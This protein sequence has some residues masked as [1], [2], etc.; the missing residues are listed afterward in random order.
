LIEVITGLRRAVKGEVIL[1]GE[2]VTNRTPREF[3]DRGIC[4]IPEERI[5]MGLVPDM[6]VAENLVL[7]SYR[8]P[9]FSRG[10]ILNYSEIRRHAEKLVSEYDVM[11][12]SVDT[13]AKL[14][15][16]GNIQ[17]LILARETSGKPRLIVAAHPTYGLDVGATEYIRRLLLKFRDGGAAILLVSEDLEEVLSLSDRIAVMFEGEFM[18]VVDADDVDVEEIG[19]MMAGVRRM[20]VVENVG[21]K[22]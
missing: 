19:L 5:R 13:P 18:G 14:L 4:H 10:P 7:K 6:S 22:G 15:S 16:G 1:L 12:P 11:T 3:I 2:D 20:E 17:R 8:H 21:D 9:P